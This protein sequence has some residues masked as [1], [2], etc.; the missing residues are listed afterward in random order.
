MR[1]TTL[2]LLAALVAPFAPVTG[3][4]TRVA[5]EGSFTV[6][7]DG[8]TAVRENFRVTAT[9]RGNV[10]E[11]F[12]KADVTLGDRKLEP[13]LRTD[14]RGAVIK[15]FVKVRTGDADETWDGEVARGRLNAMITGARGTAAREFM[16]PAGALV[17]DED[18]IHQHWFLTLRG[19][20]GRLPILVPRRDNAQSYVT[21]ATIGE[22]TLQVGT[23]DIP[24]IH[25]RV[26][27]TGGEIR[28]IWVDRGG[29]LLKVEIP[30]RSLVAVRDDP[31]R[32]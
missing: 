31:P 1:T 11:Y 2:V 3:Q 21:L 5:D 22:E 25:I 14:A 27:D 20:E 16:V 8:R 24:A 32:G 19:H 26:T 10:T 7:R 15:Y 13:E 9:T 29:R 23:Q 4:G 6:R 12:A 17:L 18:V 30:S 28:N